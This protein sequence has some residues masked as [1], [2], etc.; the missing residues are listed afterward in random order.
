MDGKLLALPVSI[1]RIGSQTWFGEIE[2]KWCTGKLAM[3]NP[4]WVKT[5]EIGLTK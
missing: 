3:L 1:V 4:M 5:D 2:M